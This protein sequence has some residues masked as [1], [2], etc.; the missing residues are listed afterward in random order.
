MSTLEAT[1]ETL[2]RKLKSAGEL[3]V[4]ILEKT[5]DNDEAK[6]EECRNALENKMKLQTPIKKIERPIAKH[7]K[8]DPCVGAAAASGSQAVPADKGVNLPKYDIAKF[9]G[10]NKDCNPFHDKFMSAVDSNVSSP[11]F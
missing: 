3:N 5:D 9:S 10:P 8:G 6:Q 11:D 2:E 4:T 7:R 1:L